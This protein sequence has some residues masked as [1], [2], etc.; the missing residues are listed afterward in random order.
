[1]SLAEAGAGSCGPPASAVNWALCD[2][3]AACVAAG[4]PVEVTRGGGTGSDGA[5]GWEGGG[6]PPA[7]MCCTA[8]FRMYVAVRDMAVCGRDVS[9]VAGGWSSAIGKGT[10]GVGCRCEQ[11]GNSGP[12][13]VRSR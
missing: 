4:Q 1:M 12:S 6:E 13:A 3:Y 9:F 11:T 7:R 10:A 8:A 5:T 2:V